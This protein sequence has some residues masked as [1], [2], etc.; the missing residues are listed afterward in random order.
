MTRA[1]PGRRTSVRDD[2][3]RGP[4]TGGSRPSTGVDA[5]MRAELAA[6]LDRFA[7]AFVT[8]D[9]AAL[10]G[11]YVTPV[12]FVTEWSSTTFDSARAITEGFR[13]VVAEHRD[14]GLVSLTHRVETVSRPAPRIVEVGVRWTFHDADGRALM[15]D[16]YRYL[17]R[18]DDEGLH[19]TAV[20]VLGGSSVP[21]K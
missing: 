11:C 21:A 16:R 12:L 5:T 18:R 17:M 20:V 8:G 15:H 9:L 4:S 1:L 7:D 13:H 10:V 6:F 2:A 14:R 3:R 19:I